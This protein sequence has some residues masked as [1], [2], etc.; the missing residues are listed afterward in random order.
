[1]G[2]ALFAALGI[3]LALC[4]GKAPS[5]LSRISTHAIALHGSA[6]A[7]VFDHLLVFADFLFGATAPPPFPVAAVCI[8][9]VLPNPNG[10]DEGRKEV[11]IGN[12]TSALGLVSQD[13]LQRSPIPK[14]FISYP[15][16]DSSGMRDGYTVPL[17]NIVGQSI[18]ANRTWLSLGLPLGGP[19]LAHPITDLLGIEAHQLHQRFITEQ[20]A[21]QGINTF[22]PKQ[23][24]Q[25]IGQGILDERKHRTLDGCAAGLLRQ[26]HHAEGLQEVKE[27]MQHRAF[28]QPVHRVHDLLMIQTPRHPR[29]IPARYLPTQPR[30]Q[31]P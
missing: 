11:T 21:R 31:V 8:L 13:T 28:I 24:L 5:H 26:S 15:R 17:H 2:F 25:P 9:S 3:A 16:E 19:A 20:Q 7:R 1:V 18:R 30:H 4:R 10:S 22:N 12:G 27:I 29:V 23:S 6:Q 14:I